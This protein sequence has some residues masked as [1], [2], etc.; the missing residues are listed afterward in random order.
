MLNKIPYIRAGWGK[1]RR[2][3]GIQTVGLPEGFVRF[4]KLYRFIKFIKPFKLKNLSICYV[5]VK[6][7]E[8]ED[9]NKRN[10]LYFLNPFTNN[11]TY[12]SEIEKDY[13]YHP[14]TCCIC[15]KFIMSDTENFEPSNFCCDKC[16]PL[17]GKMSDRVDYRVFKSAREFTIVMKSVL[18]NY[19]NFLIKYSKSN[20]KRRTTLLKAGKITV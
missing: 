12:Y 7:F 15:G 11:I 19:R 18:E 6:I 4:M 13:N 5:L 20:S 2:V 1:A 17:Y 14:W 8:L 10:R 16:K 9:H 3:H